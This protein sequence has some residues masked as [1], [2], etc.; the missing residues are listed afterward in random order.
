MSE[1]STPGASFSGEET[2]TPGLSQ[3]ERV[4]DTFIAPSKTFTDIL[5]NQSWWLPFL[6]IAIVGYG[7]IVTVDKRVGWEAVMENSLKTNQ[8]QADRINNAPAD[9]QASIRATTVASYKIFSYGFIVF[10]LLYWVVA[11]AVLLGTLNFGFGGTA[12]FGQLF[13]VFVYAGLPGI[14][15][16]VLSIVVLFA[17]LGSDAFQ[18]QNPVGT[19]LGYYLSPES[20]KWLISLGTSIDVFTIWTVVLLVIGCS[21]VAKIK[22]SSAAVAVVG[23][24]LLLTIVSV[25]FA[26]FQ[27]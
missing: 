19:N 23:W 22:R 9:Q 18:L 14:I 7:F 12:K 4:V 6:I 26:A 11:T 10:V 25:G 8:S 27:G 17:G 21:I 1:I 16:S 20:P 5:R 24:W 15:K 13:A 3:V 2:S